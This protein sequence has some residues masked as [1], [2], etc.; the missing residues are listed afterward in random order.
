MQIAF[1]EEQRFLIAK[2]RV[3]KIKGFYL[4]FSVYCLIIPLIIFANLK[5]E[6]H[7][8]WF[9]FSVLGWGTGLIVHWANVFGFPLLG[10]GKKWEDKKIR[11][12][13]KRNKIDK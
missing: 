11:E 7:Y 4:H 10:I 2:K 6:P 13:M 1:K 5:F 3:A 9:W 12:I 8:H